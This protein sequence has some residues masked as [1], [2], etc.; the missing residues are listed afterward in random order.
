MKNKEINLGEV[1]RV[2]NVS[3]YKLSQLSGIR[4]HNVQIIMQGLKTPSK[5]EHS[6]L[7][8]ALTIEAKKMS[9]F[10]AKNF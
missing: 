6:K 8:Q 9:K 10:L 2:L 3:Q 4:R 5:E 1:R 7:L